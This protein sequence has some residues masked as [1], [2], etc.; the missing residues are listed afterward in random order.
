MK[1]QHWVIARAVC[2][3]VSSAAGSAVADANSICSG[4]PSQATLQSALDG[5]VGATG[6][7]G[8]GFNMWGTIVANDGT[9]CAV[10]F[11]GSAYTS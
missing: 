11:S 1:I 3:A 10:A 4:L 9:V 2:L 8:L 7:N 5:A 6:N